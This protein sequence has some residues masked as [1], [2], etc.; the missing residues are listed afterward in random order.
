MDTNMTDGND[1]AIPL[2][3]GFTIKAGTNARRQ[4]KSAGG[5]TKREYFAAVAMQGMQ[6]ENPTTGLAHETLALCAV[7]QADALIEALN[8]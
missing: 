4:I 3:E 8:K 1:S 2:T 5:L 6:S 7:A